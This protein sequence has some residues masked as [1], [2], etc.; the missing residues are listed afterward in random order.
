MTKI[1]LIGAGAWGLAIANTIA[2]NKNKVLVY[3]DNKDVVKE[4]NKYHTTHRLPG[5]KLS[6]KIIVK[7][8]FPDIIKNAEFLFIATP[9]QVVKEVL[10]Q[11]K[12][13][14]K[15]SNK[16]IFIT[17]S[18]GIEEENLSLFSDL[19]KEIFPYNPY[20]AISG[21]NFA[22]EV[23]KKLPTTTTIA[24]KDEKIA[25]KIAK[26]MASEYFLP[27]IS[28]DVVSTQIY[29]IVKNILAIGCGVIDGLKLGENAKAVL[30]VKGIEEVN[31]LVEKLGGKKEEFLSPAGFGDLF[32]TCSSR[33]SRNNNLGFLIGKGSDPKRIL[34]D[35]DTVY[36]GAI[37]VKSVV[38]LSKKHK[39]K[40]P[41]SE[42][43]YNILY[44]Q[45]ISEDLT[46][47][48]QNTI[49]QK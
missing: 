37:S 4:V 22:I 15:I 16:T 1:S 14:G 31:N 41:I 7:D 5:V 6:S 2:H 40:M 21:P 11:V 30:L 3:S 45:K 17:C 47:I 35:Q 46:Q 27:T 23:A 44:N 20:A 12:N 10:F 24:C 19:V 8:K 25:K 29:G 32:L 36:E 33:D 48:I 18:K 39:I 26:L 28:N 42:M 38:K 49:I 43:I 13:S 9:S 34:S